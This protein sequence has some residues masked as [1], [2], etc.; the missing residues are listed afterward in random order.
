M[1]RDEIIVDIQNYLESISDS[2]KKQRETIS[3]DEN[4][5][6]VG[7]IDSMA[8]LT[9]VNWL[10]ENFSIQV[11]LGELTIENVGSISAISN[12]VLEKRS[13]E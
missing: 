10:E 3:L 2:F 4:L 1:N 12:F 9:L 11:D 7:A 8:I 13:N 5:L 6:E